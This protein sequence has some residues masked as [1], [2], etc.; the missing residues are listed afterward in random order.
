MPALSIHAVR[1]LPF[2]VLKR[3]QV[4]RYGRLHWNS[5]AWHGHVRC[6]SQLR[7]VPCKLGGF[8]DKSLSQFSRTVLYMRAN[9]FG[10]RLMGENADSEGGVKVPFDL[11]IYSVA[12]ATSM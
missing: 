9:I 12:A 4:E 5:R 2:D 7:S 11:I 8:A 6:S 1:H 3:F 10:V